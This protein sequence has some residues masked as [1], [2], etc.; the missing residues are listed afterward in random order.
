[1][2]T[3]ID[4]IK[5][6]SKVPAMSPGDTVKVNLKIKEGDKER[7]QGFQA[8]RLVR[9]DHDRLGCHQGEIDGRRMIAEIEESFG[10]VGRMDPAFSPPR[11]SR[12]YRDQALGYEQIQVK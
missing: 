3:V 5:P 10:D 8:F 12:E 2:A 4:E 9:F 7:I 1:M 11:G 6:K